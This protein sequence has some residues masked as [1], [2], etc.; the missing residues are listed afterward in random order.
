MTGL[1]NTGFRWGGQTWG[2]GIDMGNFPEITQI[3]AGK[4]W[5]NFLGSTKVFKSHFWPTFGGQS[6]SQRKLKFS[7]LARAFLV[8]K[9]NVNHAS[10]HSPLLTNED[11]Y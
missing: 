1:V 3:N 11:K 6:F 9:K 10:K 8:E 7:H 4:L 2:G 5:R